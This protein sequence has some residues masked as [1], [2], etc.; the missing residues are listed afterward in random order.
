VVPFTI[1]A[2]LGSQLADLSRREGVTLYMTLLAAFQLL[3]GRYSGQQDV[4][5][6]TDVVNRNRNETERMIGFFVNTLVMRTDL[7]G[8]PS[9]R[10]LLNRVRKVALA[11]YAHQDL[12]FERL[13]EALSSQRDLSQSPLFRV[14]M[15]M[16][17]EAKDVLWLGNLEIEPL[18]VEPGQVMFD[19]ALTVKKC[20]EEL[21]GTVEYATELFKASTI[22]R[23][24]E[25]LQVVLRRVVSNPEKPIAEI[26]YLDKVI[27]S[28][29][30]LLV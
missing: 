18:S 1:S 17:I 12:P 9:F 21:L 6:G 19:I 25:H 7:T 3:L 2:E 10:E 28:P 5:V 11:A 22:Q 13:V 16:E 23:L 8:N 29:E 4:A 14:V 15:V 30:K 20:G 26:D 27:V 24:I